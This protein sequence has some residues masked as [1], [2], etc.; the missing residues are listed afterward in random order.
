[1]D[2]TGQMPSDTPPVKRH[3]HV[4]T[5]TPT[6][7]PLRAYQ[8]AWGLGP[9][10]CLWGAEEDW[11]GR[12]GG[13]CMD[14]ITEQG[15]GTPLASICS[16]L[17]PTPQCS[18]QYRNNCP[19]SR[20]ENRHPFLKRDKP[21]IGWTHLQFHSSQTS[22]FSVEKLQESRPGGPWCGRILPTQSTPGGGGV[23]ERDGGLVPT[24]RAQPPQL[25]A[26]LGGLPRPGELACRGVHSLPHV[27]WGEWRN[28][29]PSAWCSAWHGAGTVLGLGIQ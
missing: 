6:C 11:L 10:R 16:S 13:S 20:L 19:G 25:I 8:A 22:R 23:G 17:Q 9:G 21:G 14:L 5:V 1:M 27:C 12:A 7:L 18:S 24:A 4:C 3:G 15:A 29:M 2:M 26:M 28:D